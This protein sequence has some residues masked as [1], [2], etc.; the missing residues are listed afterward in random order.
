MRSIDI[1]AALDS[2]TAGQTMK[3]AHHALAFTQLSQFQPGPSAIHVGRFCGD[4]P[5]ERHPDGDKL[6]QVLEGQVQVTLLADIGLLRETVR[7]GSLLVIPRGLWHRLTG[8]EA[9][10]LKVAPLRTEVSKAE[11]PVTLDRSAS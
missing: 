3:Q 6:L 10:V 7:A 4:M 2:I 8:Q 9:A 5:W 11:K 1:Q